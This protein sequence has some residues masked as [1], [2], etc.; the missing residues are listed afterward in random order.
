M[1]SNSTQAQ[2]RKKRYNVPMKVNSTLLEILLLTFSRH[3]EFLALSQD[4]LGSFASFSTTV[5][6]S[7]TNST[8]LSKIIDL[9]S[10]LM[11]CDLYTMIYDYEC[12]DFHLILIHLCNIKLKSFSLKFL[13]K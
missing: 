10:W 13:I 12:N 8:L 1:E 6:G 11:N 4:S 3:R 5:Q 2:F 7:F 9:S